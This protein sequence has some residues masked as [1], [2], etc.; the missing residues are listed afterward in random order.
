MSGNAVCAE[1]GWPPVVVAGAYQ[2]GVV[3]MR[4]LVRRGLSVSC[5]DCSP[6]MQGFRNAM[7]LECGDCR[8]DP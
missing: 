4:N 6:A 8:Q 3:L 7:V 5:I 1:S 2:T